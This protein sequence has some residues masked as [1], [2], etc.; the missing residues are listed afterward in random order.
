M[1]LGL[2]NFGFTFDNAK[3]CTGDRPR[4]YNRS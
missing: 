4:L 3:F 2:P 1:T